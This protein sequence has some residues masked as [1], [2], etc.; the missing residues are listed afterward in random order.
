MPTVADIFREYG[1]GYMARFGSRMLP[2]HR[3]ALQDIVD[4]RTPALG[5][6]LR[7]CDDC[8]QWHYVYHSCRNR[9]CVQCHGEQTQR[10]MTARAADLLP[11][12]YFHVVFTLPQEL[13]ELARSHQEAVLSALMTAA[14]AALQ[15]L[16]ADPRYAGGALGVL[17][18]LQTWT[19]AL[20]WHPHVHS[21]VPGLAL[22]PDG[23]RRVLSGGFLVPVMALSPIFRAKF[24]EELR[25]VLP[26][27]KLPGAV[28]RKRWVVFSR[29][30][31]EGPGNV[32][33]YLAAYVFRGPLSDRRIVAVRD[34]RVR[35]QYWDTETAEPRTVN[36]G[37]DEFIR[38]YLQHTLM[39]GFH[40]VRYYGFWAP[41]DHPMLRRLQAQCTLTGLGE[42]AAAA[43]VEPAA[44]ER[45]A[46]RCPH[47]GS[48][49]VRALA[50]W[51]RGQ[52]PPNLARGPPEAAP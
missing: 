12:V 14:V 40:R 9:A 5:G 31:L 35:I 20:I 15:K 4:C 8:G 39:P 27:L 34:G 24:A 17:A 16:A 23:R 37:T 43:V 36:L 49:Q 19:R 25:R 3:R 50:R 29:P 45:L 2:S 22:L 13:R 11:V 21:L 32:L 46:P 7:G 1:D 48:L 6:Q 28:W 26:Q 41:G 47:C 10:W 18:V 52:T 44:P 38:R 51:W 42:A 33:R 30:C